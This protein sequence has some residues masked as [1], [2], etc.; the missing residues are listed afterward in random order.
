MSDGCD[1][2]GRRR[3]NDE[4]S[5]HKPVLAVGYQDRRLR[6]L[7]G[8]CHLSYS[9]GG[10]R[11]SGQVVGEDKRSSSR[12]RAKAQEGWRRKLEAAKL[13]PP[14][15]ATGV[16][17]TMSCSNVPH[18]HR[19]AGTS[20]TTRRNV[21]STRRGSLPRTWWCR[22]QLD[23]AG[24]WSVHCACGRQANV[25]TRELGEQ[26][27]LTC[28]WQKGEDGR[29]NANAPGRLGTRRAKSRPRRGGW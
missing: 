14:R 4:A 3:W 29:S 21:N 18:F 25:G 7:S 13:Y 19:Y 8:R 5:S 11:R 9:H 23:R 22:P 20:S 1:R 24:T 16:P 26:S 6:D 12:R 28:V 17:V 27:E 2:S 15:R 10:Q